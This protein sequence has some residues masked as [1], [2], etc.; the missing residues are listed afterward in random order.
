MSS[1]I[2]QTERLASCSMSFVYGFLGAEGRRWGA[3]K[4]EREWGRKR[5]ASG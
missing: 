3:G 2:G 5:L 4:V 1:K